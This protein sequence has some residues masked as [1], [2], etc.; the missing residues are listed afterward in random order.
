MKLDLGAAYGKR[1]ITV[2]QPC[3]DCLERL[4]RG[5][6]AKL[7]RI[8]Q[9]TARAKSPDRF[10]QKAKK[11]NL[12]GKAKYADPVNEIQDQIGARIVVFYLPDVELVADTVRKYFALREERTVEPEQD[13]EFSYFGKHFIADLPGD[14]VPRE[15]D[16][17]SAPEVFELQIKTLFQHAWSES[18]HDVGYKPEIE[19]SHEQRRLLAYSSAQAWGADRVFAQ[20]FDELQPID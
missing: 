7:P 1:F 8:D 3:A 9:I 10:V 16:R 4:L 6:C 18:N 11:L 13:S 17:T 15:V 19:L 5:Y 14:G 20:L 2:L 12:D